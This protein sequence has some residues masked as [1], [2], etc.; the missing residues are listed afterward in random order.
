MERVVDIS[1]RG[2]RLSIDCGCLSLLR[3]EDEAVLIPLDDIAALLLSESAVSMTGSVLAGLAERGVAVISCDSHYLP[4]GVMQPMIACHNQTGIL[5]GQVRAGKVVRKRLWQSL[6]RQKIRHQAAILESLSLPA[7][8][9]KAITS[10][11]ASGDTRNLEGYAARL[12]WQRLAL[13]S[14]RERNA[15]DANR[16]FNYAYAVV[17][18][19]TARAVC[20]AGLHPGFGLRHHNQ[21][22]PFCLASDLMEPFRGMADHAVISWLKNHAADTSITTAAKRF[23]LSN[24]LSCR[25]TVGERRET[26][27]ATLTRSAVSLRNCLLNNRHD[28]LLPD[29]IPENQSCG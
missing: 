15:D 4:V 14:V 18:A 26:I 19:A 1:E 11:V 5:A 13:F 20:A 3:G 8:D 28:L 10:K 22:N 2:C 17:F 24:L 9:L 27:F 7:E 6:V 23:I 25:I 29:F 21:Y 16:L 12:Y